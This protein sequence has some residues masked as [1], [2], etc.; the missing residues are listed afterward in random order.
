MSVGSNARENGAGKRTIRVAAAG[1]I[2]CW[3]GR[4]DEVRGSLG[5]VADQADLLVLA[6]DLT[7]HGEPE[8]ARA[9]ARICADLGV[10]VFAILGNH[11][12]HAGKSEAVEEVLTEAGVTMLERRAV[13]HR[14]PRGDVGIVGAKGFIGGFQ[15]SHLPDFGEPLLREVYAETTRYVEALDRGLREIAHC[16]IRIVVLHYAPCLDTIEGEGEGIHA[17]LGSDRLAVPIHEHEPDL[18]VHGHAHSGRLEGAIGEVPVFN[19]SSPV[20]G[21]G[22][23]VFEF[24]AAQAVAPIH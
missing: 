16:P 24:Q 11:D 20:I 22:Y 19:V 8:E 17:F 18:V 23:W 7:T 2:H 1:D 14:T 4:E 10:P 6:G 21:R 9:L 15:G 5:D 3:P 12:W 13:V